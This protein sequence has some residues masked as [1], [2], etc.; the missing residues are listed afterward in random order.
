M[1]QLREEK[2]PEAALRDDPHGLYDIGD[3]PAA[4]R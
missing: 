4:W 2:K 3:G 1:R